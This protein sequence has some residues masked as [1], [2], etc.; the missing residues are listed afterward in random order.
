M[1]HKGASMGRL[2]KK[3]AM[4]RAKSRRGLLAVGI[5]TIPLFLAPVMAAGAADSALSEADTSCLACHSIEGLE[6][7]LPN[8]ETLSLQVSGQAFAGSVHRVIGCSACHGDIDPQA[9]PAVPSEIKSVRQ[10]SIERADGCQLC[11]AAAFEQYEGSLHAAR[12]REGHPLAPVCTGCHGFH[13]VSP[14]TA[15]ETCVGC[16]AADL[17]AH[18]KWLPN[19]GLHQEIVSC[20]ACHAPAAARMIDLR[21]YDGATKNWVTETEGAPLFEQMARSA[22]ADD[23]GLDAGELRN[24]LREINRDTTAIPMTL[25][26]RVELRTGV[27]A[28]RL[29]A[30]AHAI[31]T[32]DNCHRYGA[33]PFQNV[34]VSVTGP[35]GRLVRYPALKEVL[36]SALSVESLPEFYAIG[37]TRSPIL[38]ALLA[39]A[40]LAGVGIPIGHMTMKWLFRKYRARRDHSTGK[41]NSR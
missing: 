32:C 24:L 41:D 20:A 38:D 19:A 33:E 10:Y 27:E 18:G 22:D 25:R 23:N 35:D 28:H 21:L 4:I 30:K 1:N 7:T 34:T 2:Q 31:K 12:V 13:S 14:R 9:H 16:H 8:G 11:H 39:L 36:G 17:D 26:G 3:G 37:G 29:A 6:K 5:A 40:L 15:Y